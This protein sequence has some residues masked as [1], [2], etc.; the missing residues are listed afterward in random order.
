MK[1]RANVLISSSTFLGALAALLAT[2]PLYLHFPIIPYL[3]FE[4]AEIPIVFAFLLLGPEPAFLSSVIYW[5]VLLLVGEFTPIGPTMKFV[6]VFTM[7]LGLWAGFRVH[8]SPKA[9][10]LIGSCLGCLFRVLAMS[11]FNYVIVVIMFPEFIEI[12]AASI[13][14]FLGTG[15]LSYVPALIAILTFTA[16]FNIL[17]VIISITPAYLLVK[18]IVKIK[19]GGLPVIGKAW[20][21]EV[22]KA[23]S[24]RSLRRS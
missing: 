4:A 19:G 16:I 22:A 17:H 2:L 13:S 21:V 11:I 24:R 15:F 12:A 6:A 1:L 10:L 9:G 14:A 5:I 7:L 20:Y 8:K 23:A 18:Y 3:R